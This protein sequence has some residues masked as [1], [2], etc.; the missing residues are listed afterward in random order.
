VTLHISATLQTP[1]HAALLVPQSQPVCVAHNTGPEGFEAYFKQAHSVRTAIWMSLTGFESYQI[2]VIIF[3]GKL[4]V[5][6]SS[7]LR[8]DLEL[9]TLSYF[10]GIN[11]RSPKLLND[12]LLQKGTKVFF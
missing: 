4:S 2:G 10:S 12:R 8:K 6:V 7:E 9:F 5:P 1:V 11:N 3:G